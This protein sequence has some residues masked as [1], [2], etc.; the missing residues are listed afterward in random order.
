V[1][2][3]QRDRRR[4]VNRFLALRE[5]V[6]QA[7]MKVSP[8]T[9]PRLKEIERKRRNKARRPPGAGPPCGAQAPGGATCLTASS[10]EVAHGK[11]WSTPMVVKKCHWA[12]L[13]G[14]T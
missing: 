3:C 13:D 1:V 5:L 9:S 7:E 11:I 10:T 4:T 12:V 6:E 2:R 8:A 14:R